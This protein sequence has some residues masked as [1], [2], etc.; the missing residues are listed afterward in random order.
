MN[1][2]PN[3]ARCYNIN[4]RDDLITVYKCLLWLDYTTESGNKGYD[5]RY[6]NRVENNQKLLKHQVT[7]MILTRH[8]NSSSSLIFYDSDS[9]HSRAML[10][11]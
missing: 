1:F 10:L 4:L 8:W 6:W 7:S 11:T 3:L 5:Q 9:N 2:E